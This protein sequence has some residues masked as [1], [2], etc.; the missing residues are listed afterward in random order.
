MKEDYK[1][2]Y[3]TIEYVNRDYIGIVWGAM[4]IGFGELVISTKTFR[5]VDDEFMSLDFCKAI[6]RKS[7]I[8]ITEMDFS[9]KKRKDNE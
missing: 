9:E 8:N 1:I 3:A 2:E 4:E 7:P 5:I 6:I